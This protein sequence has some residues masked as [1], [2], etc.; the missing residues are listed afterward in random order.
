MRPAAVDRTFRSP[1]RSKRMWLAL[2]SSG[3]ASASSFVFTVAMAHHLDPVS[4]GVFAI[5]GATQALSVGLARAAVV[6]PFLAIEDGGAVRAMVH[7]SS[8]VGLLLAVTVALLGLVLNAPYFLLLALGLHGLT[9]SECVRTTN[10]A[11]LRPTSAVMQDASWGLGAIAAAMTLFFGLVSPLVAYGIWVLSGALVGYIFVALLRCNPGPSWAP[12]SLRT[13]TS[14]AFGADFLVGSG[15]ALVTTNILGVVVG[16]V[17]VGALRAAGAIFGPITLLVSVGRALAIPFLKRVQA[18]APRSEFSV[19]VRV[20]ALMGL[21]IAPLLA[22][23]A[24]LPGAVG[25]FLLGENWSSA[26]PIMPYLALELGFIV[27]TTAAFAG[28][29]VWLAGKASLIVRSFLAVVRLVVVVAAA[30]WGGAQ[31]AAVAMASVA[32]IGMVAWWFSY[33]RRTRSTFASPLIDDQGRL[34]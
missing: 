18:T 17:T 4:F 8:L 15:S 12:A 1:L 31:L 30:V 6:E 19:A 28:H 14:V 22:A 33:Y 7:R 27:L 32:F 11:R 23:L 10:M 24:F 9:I 25:R 29:R 5:A 13:S 3:I 34:R 26:E 16:P 21:M 2:G 20:S